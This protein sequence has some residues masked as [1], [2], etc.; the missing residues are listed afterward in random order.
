MNMRSCL[1]P[2]FT[3]IGLISAAP[4]QTADQIPALIEQLAAPKVRLRD[5]A[6]TALAAMPEAMD[7]LKKAMESHPSEEARLRAKKLLRDFRDRQWEQTAEVKIRKIAG[8]TQLRRITVSP[9]GSTIAGVYRGGIDL[10]DANLK[11]LRN[12][13]AI[14]K[15]MGTLNSILHALAFSPDG[16]Q[17]A[18][19]DHTGQVFIEDLEGTL[20]KTLPA[21]SKKIQ[22][23]TVT[24]TAPSVTDPFAT[25]GNTVTM[26]ERDQPQEPCG[27]AFLPD[28]KRL[29]AFSSAGLTVY[30]LGGGEKK[31]LPLAEIF[32]VSG[33]NVAARA[34]ALS[35]DGTIAGLGV[36]VMGSKDQ[37]ALVS[38]GDLKV[39]GRWLLPAIPSSIAVK[40]GGGEAVVGLRESGVLRCLPGEEWGTPFH[41]MGGGWISGLAFAPDEKSVFISNS[42]AALPL[43]QA[44]YPSGEEIWTAPPAPEG[45]EDVVCA[46]PDRIITSSTDCVIRTWDRRKLKPAADT[47]ASR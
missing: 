27:L 41:R 8:N 4:A 36:E 44:A 40:N 34:F 30:D 15:P 37:I 12:L 20:V 9:D 7:A 2:L 39:T 22:V 10:F 29:V 28:G 13:E 31:L 24:R 42:G 46:G 32:P 19:T 16:K 47:P 18:S 1:F 38:V 35:P 45:F 21:E 5:E 3:L 23:Q 14:P 33:F 26:V 43:R 25:P 17:V 11:L 6:Q